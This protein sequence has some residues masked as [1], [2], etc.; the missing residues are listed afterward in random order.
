[1]QYEASLN[2]KYA[3]SLAKIF[4]SDPLGLNCNMGHYSIVRYL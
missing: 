2:T 4:Y 3:N 1:M